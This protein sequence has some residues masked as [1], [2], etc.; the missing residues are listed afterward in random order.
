MLNN[1]TIL[2]I[3]P[4]SWDFLHV[5]KHHYA[6]ELTRQ[7]NKVYFL[8]TPSNAFEIKVITENL[9]VI[10]YKSKFK[11]TKYY[12]QFISAIFTE[13]EIK[14]LEK[15]A[16]IKF[17]VVWNFDT[18]RFFNLSRLKNKLKI[19]H[20]VDMAENHQRVLLTSTSDICFCTS[21]FI[22]R[23]IKPYNSKVFKIHH[24]YQK[25]EDLYNFPIKENNSKIQVGIVGNLSRT[26]IDWKLI[27][28]L[29][30]KYS[31]VHFNFVGSYSISV[32]SNSTSE[33]NA[34]QKLG[35]CS[36][37]TLYGSQ[38]SNLIPNFLSYMDI[39]LC[40]YKI[41]NED[42]IAQH[43]NLHK[44]MEYLGSGKIV[45]T[46]YVDEFKN[47]NDLLLMAKPYLSVIPLFDDAVSNL[48]MYNDKS[49]QKK[50]ISFALN[51]SYSK[52]IER[53]E[54]IIIKNSII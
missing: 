33:F 51:N 7:K 20:L 45:V 12:P 41:E 26:C 18:S 36:N 48:V 54:E 28:E 32:P 44:I 10:D 29:T 38:K 53:I 30:N 34:L 46:S 37:V 50:R 49:L 6:K 14:S 17:D 16:G 3:S 52:Q 42:D 4:N 47:N 9:S 15:R 2:I 23:E 43:S 27:L 5:S 11:G 21:E 19:C 22:K 39:L 35:Q 24:G 1:K 13:I 31:D 25:N 40:A 8:N